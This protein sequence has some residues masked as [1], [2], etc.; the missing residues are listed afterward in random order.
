MMWPAR[1]E[2]PGWKTATLAVVFTAF[3]APAAQAYRPFDLTDADVAKR[4]IFEI[5]MGPAELIGAGSEHSLRAP[6][7]SINYG[8]ARGRELSLAGANIVTLNPVPGS[9]HT[10]LEDVAIEMKQ[11]V[12][13]GDLQDEPGPSVAMEG[14][15]EF[16]GSG[17]QHLGAS[18]GLIVSS[19]SKRRT[20]HL[21]VEGERQPDGHDAGSAGVII[22][23]SDHFGIAPAI[24]VRAEVVDGGLPEQSVILGLIYVPGVQTEYDVA[25]RLARRGDEGTFEIR[26]GLTWQFSA[27]KALETAKAAVGI[28]SRRR[29]H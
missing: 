1:L 9:S 24:E 20:T 2:W 28:P 5:E 29:R 25:L 23:A 15:L 17:E 19:A 3:L 27:R 8:L 26:A 7:L 10:Q 11:V 13:R 18:A 22:E 12:R 16:P 21:N 4:H 6:N 14:A